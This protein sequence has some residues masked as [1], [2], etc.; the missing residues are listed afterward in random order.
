MLSTK[1]LGR[2]IAESVPASE[3]S[4]RVGRT[5]T[6]ADA[7]NGPHVKRHRAWRILLL[8]SLLFAVSAQ[9]ASTLTLAWDRNPETNIAGYKLYYG[10]TSGSYS[11][12]VNVGNT[13][14]VTITNLAHGGSWFFAVTAYNSLGVESDYSSE[15]SHTIFK[16]RLAPA[17]TGGVTISWDS[18]PGSTYRVL[19]KSMISGANWIN[20]SGNVAAPAAI[21]SWTDTAAGASFRF[22]IV[23]KITP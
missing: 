12:A 19:C 2:S 6:I 9:S 3:P 7:A 4:G 18:Q 8:V 10:Q 16:V 15:L 13:T 21:A 1:P 20:A 23:E 17:P 11:T 5:A 22:Y 14:T